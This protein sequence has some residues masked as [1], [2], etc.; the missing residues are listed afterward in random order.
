MLTGGASAQ[1]H[2]EYNIACICR[3]EHWNKSEIMGITY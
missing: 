1:V 3:G 2:I